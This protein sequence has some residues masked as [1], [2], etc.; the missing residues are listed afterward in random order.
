V[1]QNIDLKEMERKAFQSYYEDGI[2]D[3]FL[4]LIMISMYVTSVLFEG[5]DAKLVRYGLTGVTYMVI[6]LFLGLGKKYI[7]LP[8]LGSVKFG[9]KRTTDRKKNILVNLIS[10]VVLVIAILAVRSFKGTPDALAAMERSHVW[11][12]IGLGGWVA[13][14]TILGAYFMDFPRLY[15]YGVM[16]GIGFTGTMLLDDPIVFVIVGVFI[17][18]PGIVIFSRFLRDH[19]LPNTEGGDE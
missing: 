5:I 13:F 2:W 11:V 9:K 12:S 17:L 6:A 18:V 10:L 8:R 19:P 1:T 4:G 15:V 16:Y 14:I 3:M 7:T